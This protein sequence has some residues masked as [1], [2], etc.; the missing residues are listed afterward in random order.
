MNSYAN[1]RFIAFRFQVRCGGKQVLLKLLFTFL[2][3]SKV[4]KSRVADPTT[5]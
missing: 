5:Y 1:C 4:A 3:T 2:R